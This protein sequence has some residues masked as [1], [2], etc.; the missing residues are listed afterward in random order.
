MRLIEN[1]PA[2]SFPNYWNGRS[3]QKPFEL[4]RDRIIR[5]NSENLYFLRNELRWLVGGSHTFF[6]KTYFIRTSDL[7]RISSLKMEAYTFLLEPTKTARGSMFL[8]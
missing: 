5:M 4:W 1:P 7:A 2:I 6:I 3:E 8:I